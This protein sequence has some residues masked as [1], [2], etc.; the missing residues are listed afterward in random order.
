MRR[1]PDPSLGVPLL[2]VLH[3][4]IESQ[5]KFM[6]DEGQRILFE[7][8]VCEAAAERLDWCGRRSSDELCPSVNLLQGRHRY[9]SL[10]NSVELGVAII[11]DNISAVRRLGVY[12]PAGPDVDLFTSFFGMPLHFAARYG[13]IEIIQTL[14]EYGAEIHIEQWDLRSDEVPG[15]VQVSCLEG[16]ALRVAASAGH[17]DAVKLLMR[18]LHTT[19][20]YKLP[21]DENMEIILGAARNGDADIVSLLLDELWENTSLLSKLQEDVLFHSTF[22]GSLEIVRNMLDSGVSANA[23]SSKMSSL[24]LDDGTSK[25]SPLQVAASRGRT[26]VARL[27]LQ[28]GAKLDYCGGRITCQRDALYYAACGGYETTVQLLLEYGASVNGNNSIFRL[29]GSKSLLE[30]V[31]A[32]DQVHILRLL[33]EKGVRL[34][35]SW[36]S[37]SKSFGASSVVLVIEHGNLPMVLCL[38]ESGIGIPINNGKQYLDLVLAAKRYGRIQ[39][40]RALLDLGGKDVDQAK[41]IFAADFAKGFYPTARYDGY[42]SQTE[43]SE[44][45]HSQGR[46]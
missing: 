37:W 42:R 6:K 9:S 33:L 28:R 24:L 13:R 27:L 41:S 39:I 32:Y 45:F 43:E 1:A 18:S 14:L 44:L 40:L 5:T 29:S 10:R 31:I 2:P 12:E 35:R 46:Y 30:S 8:T 25:Y 23:R 26:E 3:K 17:R 7:R 19:G 11:A 16:S 34:K 20:P 36:K 38:L 4:A 15:A 21:E 22:S